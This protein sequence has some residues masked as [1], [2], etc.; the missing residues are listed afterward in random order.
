MSDEDGQV[1]R[2]GQL[3]LQL[4]FPAAR[5]IAIAAASVSQDQE[6]KGL[7]PIPTSRFLPPIDEVIH[8]K[9][10]GIG[11]LSDKDMP[12][13]VLDIVNP[14]GNGFAEGGAGEVV[15]VD[16][17]GFF[18]P[19]LPRLKEVPNQLLLFGIYTDRWLPQLHKDFPQL[20]DMDELPVAVGMRLGGQPFDV[21]FGT[22]IILAQQT[23][24]R[25]AGQL[26]PLR[27]HPAL[28]FAQAALDPTLPILRVSCHIVFDKLQQIALYC[29]V[30]FSTLGR[31]PPGKRPRS[32]G[33]PSKSSISS[34][35]P[36]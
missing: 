30:F 24:N 15:H 25:A 12:L 29:G 1:E 35:R 17:G 32:V 6:G 7:R 5:A 9:L 2:V 26:I 23:P 13:V 31:P 34:R 20:L 10:R 21:A 4:L 18:T 28:D 27:D 16:G 36:R 11:G 3:D 22:Q 8:S 14:I 19:S 33:R